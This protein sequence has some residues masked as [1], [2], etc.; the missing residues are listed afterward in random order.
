MTL[1]NG[2]VPGSVRK[3]NERK[4]ENDYNGLDFDGVIIDN[5]IIQ[6]NV[7]LLSTCRLCLLYQHKTV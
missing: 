2:F 5:R 1:M 7:V 6:P 4:N 3:E